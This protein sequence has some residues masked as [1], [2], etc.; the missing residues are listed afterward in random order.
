MILDG[1]TELQKKTKTKNKSTR[2]NKIGVITS[3]YWL[4]KNNNNN[5]ISEAV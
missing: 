1:H 4:F 3:K 5:N 2:K